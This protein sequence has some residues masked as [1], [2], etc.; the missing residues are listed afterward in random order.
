MMGRPTAC[1]ENDDGRLRHDLEMD[2]KAEKRCPEERDQIQDF[3]RKIVVR[4]T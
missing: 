2:M 3:E 4:K 1:T